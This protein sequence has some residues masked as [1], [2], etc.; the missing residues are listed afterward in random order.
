MGENEC[1]VPYASPIP[2]KEV[3][4]PKREQGTVVLLNEHSTKLTARYL[5]FCSVEKCYS[6]H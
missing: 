4:G 1:L 3:V 5:C 6:E 2:V